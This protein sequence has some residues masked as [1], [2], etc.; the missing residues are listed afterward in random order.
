MKDSI[1]RSLDFIL[2]LAIT[3]AIK[4]I[5]RTAVFKE[6]VYEQRLLHADYRG[7]LLS[8]SGR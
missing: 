6:S 1:D 7:V 3:L 8:D 5:S 4:N 2:I